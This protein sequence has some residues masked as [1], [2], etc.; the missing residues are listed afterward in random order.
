M[1]S[2]IYRDP[3]I[4]INAVV[5]K[6]TTVR[7]KKLKVG[8]PVKRVTAGSFDITNLGGVDPAGKTAGS[9]LAYNA[10]TTKWSTTDFAEGS[11]ISN[12]FDSAA[13]TFT[14]N[15]KGDSY[16]GDLIPRTSST[17]SVVTASIVTTGVSHINGTTYSTTGGTGTGFTIRATSTGGL[18]SFVIVTAGDG[19]TV[20]DVVSTSIDVP[21]TIRI[22]SILGSTGDLGSSDLNWKKLYAE[23]VI[24]N[25]TG[26]VTGQTSDISNHNTG[27]LTEGS[28]LYFTNARS[29]G[30]ISV[31]D[32][33]GDGSLAY[34]NSTGVITYTGASA[35]EVR[36]HLTANKGLSVTD[37]EFNIDSANVRG[38]FSA[39]GDLSYNSG[40]GQFSVDVENV[41]TKANFDSDLGLANTG[42]LPEGS[43]LYYTDARVDARITTASVTATGALMDSEL[44]DLA[45]VKGVT[46]STLQPKPSEGAFVDGDKTK[47][48]GIEASADVTDTAN[49]TSA[50]ALMDSELT[51]LAGVKGVTI[52]TLQPKPSEGAFVDGDK[53]KLDAIESG[54]TADQTDAEI[55]TAYENNSDTN[56]FTD[57][58]KTKLTNIEAS[59][60]VT[61]TANV[62]SA[63]ALMDSELTDLVGVKGVTISTLQVKPTEGAFVDGDKTKLDAIEASADVTDTANVTAAGALMDSE[64]TDLAGV[65]GVTISTLQVKPSE[66]AFA[67]GDKTKLDGIEASADVTDTANVTS[68]GALMDSELAS[69]ADVKALDQSVVSGATPTFTTTNFTDDTD[70][71]FM[72]DAQESKLD[73]IEASATADQTDAEI[74]A[75]VEAATDSNVFTDA[76]HTKL[77]AIEAS[78]DVT[79]TANVTA[80]GALMDS[81]VDADI[82]TLSL[83][84]NTT[85]SAFGKTLVDDADAATARTTLGVD[86]SGTDNSTDVTLA[87][88]LDYIT[89]SGQEITR[90]AINLSTDVTGTLPVGNMA[91]TALT[92]VQ[93]AANESAHLAL[94]AQEGD[95]VVRSDQNKTYMH[96][97]GTAGTMDD[98]TLLATPTDA[99]TSV[100]GNTGVVTVTENV[101]TNLSITG[102]DAART[103]VSSDGTDAVIP[104]ATDSVSGVMSAADH[105][106]LTGIETSAD[107][108]DTANVTAAGA[109]M[110]SEL[111]SIAD[112]KALDQSVISGASPTFGTANMSDATNKRFMTDAQETKLDSVESSADV[113]D[114]ANVTAAG[115][116]MD[117]ELTD[118]AGVK[119]VT[120]STLQVKPSEGAFA[121][122]D[123]TKLD[124]IE[125]SADVTDTANV[126]AA[127]ALMDS[128]L[129][130][131]AGVKGVTI[132]TLQV[133]PSEGAFVDGDKTKLDAIEASADVTDTAN[134]TA[135]GA[136]MDSELTDLAGVKGV[137]ISTLQVKPSEGAFANG[138]KTKLDG[139]EASADV[140]DTANVTSAG[141]VMDSELTSIADVKALDQSVVSGSSPNFATTNMTDA[142]NKRFMTDAQETKL[143][144]VESSADVTDTANV[145][146][147]GAL[148]DSELASIADVKALDQSVISGASPTFG[149]ANM[150]DASNKRF[151]SD[152]Q[153]T[154]LDSVESSATADQ[155][156]AEILTAVKTVDGA[157]SGLDA[158]LLDGV[159][160][161]SYLRSDADD[162][163]TG[164]LQVEGATGE[165]IR[166]HRSDTTVSGG[167]LIGQ[168]AF[169][170]DDD[171][172]S[173][174]GVLIKGIANGGT[175]N[176]TLQIHTGTPGSLTEKIR[177]SDSKVENKVDL[178]VT[179]T[180]K[181]NGTGYN[182]ANTQWATNAALITTGSYGG[183]LTFVDGSAGYSIRVENSG[184]D[185]VIG[186]GATSGALTQKVKITSA[187]I[188]VNGN[189]EFNGL[190]GTGA[191]TVTDIL[192]EDDMSTN[193]ATMLATQQSIKAYVDANAGSMSNAQVRAAVEA[194]TDS[195]VFTDADHSKLNAIEA[196]ADV[197]DATNVT[198]AG[199]L[200]DSELASI[201]DVKALDQ[202]VVSG[203][204][205]TFATTNM[206]DAS[207]KRFMSDAQE[208]K[209]DGIEASATADQTAAQILTAI[210]TVD[211]SGSGLDADVLDGIGS[212]SF[213]RSDVDDAVNAYSTQ[214]RF[215][216]NTTGATASGDQAS[217]EVR[218]ATGNSDAF[219]TFHVAGDFAA[220]FGIDGTTNDLFVGGWSMGANKYKIWHQNN[221]G[222]GSGLDAD[223][224][225]GVQGASYLRSDTSDTFTGTLTMAG[226]LQMNGNIINDCEDIYLRDR[227][228]H[229]D[230]TNTYMQFHAA[231]QFR[232][233]T[234]GV[235]RLEV[236]NSQV[237][238]QGVLGVNT[239]IQSLQTR[240]QG[241]TDTQQWI[242]G[243]SANFKEIYAYDNGTF[244]DRLN[245]G[246]CT[247]YQWGAYSNIPIYTITN[248]TIR[249]TLLG[250]GRFGIGTTSP[251]DLL[252]V[253]GNIYLGTSSRT[254]YTS[255]SGNLQFQSNTG[256]ILFRT[257]N[258]GT[259]NMTTSGDG[260]KIATNLTIGSQIIHDGDTNTY[261]Q[262]HAADQWRVVTGGTERLE[263]NNTATTVNQELR[264]KGD[265]NLRS[266]SNTAVRYVHIPR[267]GGVTF[268]GDASV[269]HSI[270]SRNISGTASDDIHIASYGSVI[271]K[272]DSNNNQ[273]SGAD[274]KIYRNGTSTV[275]LTVSGENGNLTAEGDVTAFSDERLK[276]NIT[277]I[278]NAIEKVSQIRGVTYTRNDQKDKEKV[279]AGVIAQE[280]EKVLPEVVNTTEDDTKTVAYG[281]MVGLLIEAVKEQQE[282]IN[283]LKKQIEEMK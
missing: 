85:I 100:N 68:A 272:L 176:T 239:R 218:Q 16:D 31:T 244:Y 245:G 243:S 20:G 273:T 76:D 137:T 206:T 220:Y 135:A 37:G 165:T 126:T 51:D 251:G 130:D 233:V 234:G 268:Y 241:T 158:D 156:A 129:T 199:A 248:N 201:A 283:Q 55:K 198:A 222:S 263:V 124:G 54:A 127:G 106:K 178:E 63:G 203:A 64:L 237:T 82:K 204:S 107:V 7:V 164:T 207:N 49:V 128:E 40:T 209:L 238:V 223:T 259:T 99:V 279:Y 125:A 45:G 202:S 104:V 211:G 73:G 23:S 4:K 242:A 87:G 190:S 62:T 38:M 256:E 250:N 6:D 188:D 78:A 163:F 258:G 160:G 105:T 119:G 21:A 213:L 80:A 94:T 108:T 91:A 266:D 170:H 141:A 270:T 228:F 261:T 175:G 42:Q 109:L 145:T 229:D 13:N 148:M 19:Y 92:T 225:D 195:N 29:R 167:N 221:D 131:L 12:V 2:V 48:D 53:T 116:L 61:D 88:S 149:T 30:S 153:E 117:S 1:P 267:G 24:G 43:N 60:D 174:D 84:A 147:A 28:N 191:V 26:N 172:N 15:F 120:I 144:S 161:A 58:E 246:N 154:K 183:G 113:T 152:A 89:I 25:L 74:R 79:D 83:P 252:H 33:G 219:M 114:T 166:L 122:G 41:Y 185:L 224:L 66:G 179:G 8:T 278:P 180:T 151:M 138:D 71:R 150:T 32:A 186:Q 11:N 34:N 57:A 103:I 65:K 3:K 146:S 184:A 132:S 182:P 269:N 192:D 10:S 155:T 240:T 75:A 93:T 264:P 227:I 143:D 230:D 97:G 217:L 50:G 133:K 95:V 197:T 254:V 101:T 98:Y 171:T 208:T 118:L 102:T 9:I 215:P 235:E 212:G 52:S 90:N 275:A 232:V 274:F 168:I 70:K 205:P 162:T 112:V 81:E 173:G 59:A 249:T 5:Y 177:V 47:L 189:V 44:T 159:Q 262:F 27:D 187:G 140:T 134:V 257:A 210:K 18:V 255:G 277:V 56:A 22:N 96:N 216:S 231:D 69:I 276:E 200:M 67:N 35:A 121:N 193:S 72:T 86:A 14:F 139:I 271:L 115:A 236:N 17:G 260:M 181:T 282:Q 226:Q 194:A 39:S 136:L 214:I 247:N 46:I 196:S 36:A 253:E 110:D 157:S 281:N 111:A 77:N 265:L 123:K 280:V 142:S 169:S